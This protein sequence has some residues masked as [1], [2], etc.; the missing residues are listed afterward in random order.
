MTDVIGQPTTV[1]R[2][3]PERG[4]CALAPYPQFSL[5]LPTVSDAHPERLVEG[6]LA[7][8]A[9][10]GPIVGS[11]LHSAY[12]KAA[13][14][15]MGPRIAL[16]LTK[17]IRSAVRKGRLV[18]EDP[19]GRTGVLTC[20]YRLHDQPAVVPRELGARQFDQVPPAELAHVM[21]R[22]A[23]ELGWANLDAVFRATMG[24]Y[25][26]RR[27]G[28]RVRATLQ[29][30]VG[31]ASDRSVRPQENTGS[32]ATPV[33][34]LLRHG[35]EIPL[36]GP[37][38]TWRIRWS[39]GPVDLDASPPERKRSSSPSAAANTLEWSSRRSVGGTAVGGSARCAVSTREAS[40]RS[41]V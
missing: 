25:G 38:V 15:R 31:L 32:G 18:R 27:M 39:A 28:H 14:H 30:V 4:A 36:S 6:V 13:G 20:T 29:S 3:A 17:A 11:R 26:I 21:S 40:R 12:G 23:A 19:F 22:A 37:E 8:V 7:I 41:P 35:E 33:A 9:V 5:P 1:H 16:A 34:R 2:P 10:E 24:A